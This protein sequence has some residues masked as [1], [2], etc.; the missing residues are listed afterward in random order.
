MLNKEKVFSKM[1][2]N[3]FVVLVLVFVNTSFLCQSQGSK[4]TPAFQFT[5]QYSVNIN[6]FE[7]TG[8]SETLQHYKALIKTPIC[9]E[10][11]CYEVELLFYW[12]QRI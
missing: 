3:Y 7:E 5:T 8:T 12:D 1:I 9:E 11:D 2:I 6:V 4:P 10:E